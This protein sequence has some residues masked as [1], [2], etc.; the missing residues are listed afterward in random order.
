MVGHAFAA[1][2]IIAGDGIIEKNSLTPAGLESGKKQK[3]QKEEGEK[4]SSQLFSFLEEKVKEGT[5]H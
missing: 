1:K 2:N 4:F 3:A 5:G